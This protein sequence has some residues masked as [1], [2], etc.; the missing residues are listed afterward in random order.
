[1]LFSY[2]NNIFVLLGIIKST[3]IFRILQTNKKKLKLQ[4]NGYYFHQNYQSKDSIY[5]LC[6]KSRNL[7]CKA[8]VITSREFDKVQLKSQMHNHAPENLDDLIDREED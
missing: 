2:I 3:G 5:W 8:R 1:M 4:M 7:K 6:S